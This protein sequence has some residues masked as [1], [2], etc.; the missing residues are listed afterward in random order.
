[1]TPTCC[2]YSTMLPNP[3]QYPECRP[4]TWDSQSTP[5]A[6]LSARAMKITF[7][8]KQQSQSEPASFPYDM[9]RNSAHLSSLDPQYLG[10]TPASSL[11]APPLPS[12]YSSLGTSRLAPPKESSSP[13]GCSGTRASSLPN[14]AGGCGVFQS[15][16]QEDA[17]S[18]SSAL[19][20]S[21]L[22]T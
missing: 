16:P 6:L 9:I 22:L 12:H 17:A 7:L 18:P 13:L 3:Q 5:C 8:K 10:H 14:S 11:L 15:Q 2:F 19:C 21:S 4:P 20:T 1:M